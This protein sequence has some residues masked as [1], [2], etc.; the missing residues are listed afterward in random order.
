MRRDPHLPSAHD[1][2]TERD[3]YIMPAAQCVPS[4]K[5]LIAG[6]TF[7]TVTTRG[8]DGTLRSRPMVNQ[9]MA[10]G[11]PLWFFT[12]SD[13]HKASDI[14]ADPHVNVSYSD[15]AAQRCISVSGIAKIINDRRKMRQLWRPA[16]AQWLPQGINDPDLSLLEIGIDHIGYWYTGSARAGT[17]W[18]GVMLD[19]APAIGGND[20]DQESY[21][22]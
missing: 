5:D 21:T 15:P 7:A 11:G 13:T 9:E 8:P 10:K 2:I 14:I 18:A 22:P 20:Y 3:L 4:L 17:T 1:S 16:Y 6:I 12:G 19:H